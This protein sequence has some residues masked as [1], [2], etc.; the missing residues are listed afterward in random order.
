MPSVIFSFICRIG[1][2]SCSSF[3]GCGLVVYVYRCAYFVVRVF[4]FRSA[5]LQ[6]DLVASRPGPSQDRPSVET[7]T[8]S[9]TTWAP[10]QKKMRISLFGHYTNPSQDSPR[11]ELQQQEKQLQLYIEHI[12]S[13][14][15]T[16]TSLSEVFNKSEFSLLRHFF[17][18][19]FCSPAS[20]A[21]VERVFSQSGLLLRPHRSRMTDGLLESLVYLKCN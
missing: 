20:S 12:N 18:H 13:P 10:P 2:S 8:T 14:M 7:Q 16:S 21:P 19:M 1:I 15:P 11:T 4:M 6:T 5:K 9:S 3:V 17:E